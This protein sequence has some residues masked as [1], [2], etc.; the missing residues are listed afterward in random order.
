LFAAPARFQCCWKDAFNGSNVSVERKLSDET[1]LFERSRV[2]PFAYRDHSERDWQIKAGS[3]FLNVC[4]RE[5]DGRPFARWPE[6][7][8]RYRGPNSVSALFY[9]HIGQTDND[10]N[11]LAGADIDLDFDFVSI[12]AVNGGGIYLRE[13]GG[14]D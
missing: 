5:V 9:G 3:F 8:V 10:H 2:Q 13:H 4:R 1:E 11:R 6:T 12:N 14:T 7:T